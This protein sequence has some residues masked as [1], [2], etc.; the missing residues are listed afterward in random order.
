M[1]ELYFK[2]ILFLTKDRKPIFKEFSAVWSRAG[3]SML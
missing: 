1:E 2:F 3:S